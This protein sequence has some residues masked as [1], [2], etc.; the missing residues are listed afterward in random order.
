M[1]FVYH[2]GSPGSNPGSIRK[3]LCQTNHVGHIAVATLNMEQSKRKLLYKQ[4]EK[5]IFS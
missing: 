4:P 1:R 3:G 5:D 2:A